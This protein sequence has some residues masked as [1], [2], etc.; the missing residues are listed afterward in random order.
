MNKKILI[1]IILTLVIINFYKIKEKFSI[2]KIDDEIEDEADEEAILNL[3]NKVSSLE[4]KLK[5]LPI[6]TSNKNKVNIM[7]Y[8]DES[9]MTKYIGKIESITNLGVICKDLL[10]G[11]NLAIPGNVNVY[12][13]FDVA[14]NPNESFITKLKIKIAE[15]EKYI[16]FLKD[17]A[18]AFNKSKYLNLS[19]LSI[20]QF[21]KVYYPNQLNGPPM[22][23]VKE[24]LSPTEVSLGIKLIPGKV[25]DNFSLTYYIPDSRN[26][27]SGKI[28]IPNI[29]QEVRKWSYYPGPWCEGGTTISFNTN[30]TGFFGENNLDRSKYIWTNAINILDLNKNPFIINYTTSTNNNSGGLIHSLVESF[31]VMVNTYYYGSIFLDGVITN[32][33]S[34]LFLWLDPSWDWTCGAYGNDPAQY[35][36]NTQNYTSSGC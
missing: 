15:Q 11:P 7:N 28:K 2:E 23:I 27:F 18:S 34:P 33:E 24:V 26:E 20:Y 29:S 25:D 3:R 22:T 21:N 14:V 5:N 8:I 32:E 16:K 35:T 12:G 19:Y 31:A 4:N 17:R 6:I 13:E 1:L 10:D 9:L 36:I 30:K